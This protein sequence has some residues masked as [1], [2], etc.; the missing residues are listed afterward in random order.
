MPWCPTC[1]GVGPLL[2]EVA[3][4]LGP[5]TPLQVGLLDASGPQ[6]P[7]PHPELEA[8]LNFCRAAGY[9]SLFLCAQGQCDHFSGPWQLRP[10]M[11]WV[12]GLC[13]PGEGLWGPGVDEAHERLLGLLRARGVPVEDDDEDCDACSL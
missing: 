8:A 1:E 13:G 4:R 10:L 7:A 12:G 3:A 2:G 9:P 11:Q 5:M 6:D